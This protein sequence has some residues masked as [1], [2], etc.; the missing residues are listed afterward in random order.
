MRRIIGPLPA[1]LLGLALLACGA[2]DERPAAAA[3]VDTTRLVIEVTGA[4]P[5]PQRI[6][7]RCGGAEPCEQSRIDKL[8]ALAEPDDPAVACT[9][10]YGGSEQAHMTGT[11]AG[12][13]VDVTFARSD[14]CAIADYEA[15]FAALG[16]EPPLA[17]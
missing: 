4:E 7:L 15:L 10:Q 8:A 16:R 14:G 2:D 3:P 9:Q 1:L 5:D 17:R 12:E 13:P 11:L 6:E